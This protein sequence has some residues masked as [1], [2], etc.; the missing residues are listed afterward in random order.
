MVRV[1][2]TFLRR[3]IELSIVP[4]ELHHR[5]RLNKGFG[6]EASIP[7]GVEWQ[8]HDDRPSERHDS[9]GVDD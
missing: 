2:H 7:G 4:K 5:V 1:G 6:M 8:E 9:G 3:M